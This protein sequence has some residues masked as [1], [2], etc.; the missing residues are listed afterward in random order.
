MQYPR[1]APVLRVAGVVIATLVAALVPA[2]VAAAHGRDA[3]AAERLLIPSASWHG[4]PIQQPHRHDVSRTA[5]KQR[6]VG[7]SAGPVGLGTGTHRATGSDR[8]REVQRRLRAL[9]YRPGPVDGI[10]GP[11]TRAAVGWFQVKHGFPVTGRASLG[12]VRHL[13]ARTMPGPDPEPSR[14]GEPVGAPQVEPEPWEAYRELVAW[15][16]SGVGSAPEVRADW[17]TSGVALLTLFSLGF[18]APATGRR[19]LRAWFATP[20]HRRQADG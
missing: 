11:R 1:I 20:R 15:S 14:A 12:V 19:C 8:V 18:A 4:R 7:W 6:P 9:G 10:F 16:P 2:G 5:V 3:G 13:R 17:W